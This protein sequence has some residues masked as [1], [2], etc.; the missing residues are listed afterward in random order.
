MNAQINSVNP[1]TNEII[2]TFP[3]LNKKEIE[4]KIQTARN[5]QQSWAKVSLEEKEQI[6]NKFKEVL[7]ANIDTTAEIV[8][9]ECGKIRPDFEAEIYDVIDA[10]DY[11]LNLYKSIKPS[12][13]SPNQIAFPKTDIS[14]QYVPYGIIAL[15]MP[16]NFPFYSPMMFV[17]T[18][19]LTGNAVLLKPSEYATMVGIEI[20]RLI[21]LAG[22][23]QDL[24]QI[25]SGGEETGRLLVQSNVDKIFF[26]GSV[27]AGKDIM[28][29][30]GIKSLQFELGG[31][32]AAIVLEDADIDLA[33][34]G[35]VW[36][37]TYHSGQD[38]VGIKRII[39]HKSISEEFISKAKQL[40]ES[41]IPTKDF[42]PYITKEARNEVKRRID[43]AV[44]AGAE[45]VT[46]GEVP[47][48]KELIAGNW[49]TPSILKINN[50]NIELIEKETFGNVIPIIIVDSDE[51]AIKKA[52]N[53][54][55][56]LSNAIF[57]QNPEKANKLAAQLESGMVFINDPFIAF[58][59]WD[60]W[61]GWKN[62][63]FGSTESK[64]M[65]C[66]RKKVISNNNS[67]EGRSFWFPY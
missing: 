36:G 16:W 32:S 51:E 58:P 56:G 50:E 15:I 10:I 20:K 1:F 65:Q 8:K 43:L 45:L 4:F 25:I 53:T 44:E 28:K 31:N 46:G 59:G 55:Y 39:L 47:S 13:I 21:E 2:A 27:E 23:P 64:L 7:T 6:F 37:A 14:I 11:Y 60:H 3:A 22:F 12:E 63:G 5:V 9:N 42:G 38:C 49:L 40:V 66:L 24:L 67:G 17:I 18:S 34:N 62:S 57:S 54:E 29:N 19:I 30:A 35:I 41:L 52:N 48:S 61:T 33:V 26:V